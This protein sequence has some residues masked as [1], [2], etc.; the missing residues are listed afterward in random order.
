M[1]IFCFNIWLKKKKK[2]KKKNNRIP[3]CKKC[4]V[5]SKFVNNNCSEESFTLV[6]HSNVFILFDDNR[7]WKT[8]M[9]KN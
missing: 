6:N 9:Q 5:C 8:K 4:I 2:K 1:S 7:W 3:I